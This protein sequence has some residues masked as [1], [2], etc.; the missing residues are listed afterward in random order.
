MKNLAEVT[1]GDLGGDG[2]EPVMSMPAGPEAALLRV[3]EDEATVAVSQVS[4]E[5][6]NGSR[7]R[8]IKA[9]AEHPSG[10]GMGALVEQL[11]DESLQE[12][13]RLIAALQVLRNQL[14]DDGH[15]VQ[16]ELNILAQVGDS[17]MR[18]TSVIGKALGEWRGATER[19]E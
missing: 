18:T 17:A 19:G 14:Y 10:M 11:V 6:L 9:A 5:S 7:A 2:E 4:N 3:V 1:S 16:R 8:P 12:I 13:D 15:R